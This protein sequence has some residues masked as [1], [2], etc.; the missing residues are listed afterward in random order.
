VRRL[1]LLLKAT[2]CFNASKFYRHARLFFCFDA[3]T[4]VLLFLMFLLALA[5]LLLLLLLLRLLL[6]S[7]RSPATVGRAVRQLLPM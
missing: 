7:H 3:A 1:I 4:S 6:L 5:L 2:K